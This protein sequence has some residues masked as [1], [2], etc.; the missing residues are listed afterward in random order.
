MNPAGVSDRRSLWPF[1]LLSATYLA[2]VG[3]FNPYLPLWLKEQDISLVAIGVLTALQ[4]GTRVVAPYAWGWLSDHTGERVRWLRLCAAVTFIASLGL[5]WP[6]SLGWLALVLVIMFLHSSAMMPMSEGALAHW[7]SNEEGFD[8]RRYG[9][10]RLWGS[11][12]FMLAVLAA[13]AWFEAYGIKDFVSWTL[14]SLALVNVAAWLLP[15]A[16]EK[17]TQAQAA[18]PIWPILRQPVVRGFLLSVFLHILA[19]I[20]I[21][22]YFSLYLDALGYTKFDIGALWAVSVCA[23]ILW[24]Y[25]QGRWMHL[26]QPAT[27]MRVCAVI[28]LLRMV[29]TA[30]AA[31]IP[32][33]LVFAQALHA[34]TFA[35]H[36]TVA[37]GWLNRHFAPRLRGRGQALY[38][39]IGY[40]LSGVLGALAGGWVSENMGLQAVFY[41]C[42]G[43]ALLAVPVAWRLATWEAQSQQVRIEPDA[44]NLGSPGGHER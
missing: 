39:A 44:S 2:H 23:E 14:V 19:H 7:L 21:Y 11:L 24:F 18:E 33:L 35:T 10:L 17:A 37:M 42:V 36:H 22:V 27:W 12:G 15:Q 38:S 6:L 16:H 41:G 8:A 3:F 30:T 31:D 28:L 13:G 32:A 9:R 5:L 26:L 1:A 25:G 4:A 20:G 34:V 29:I 43:V 40:G